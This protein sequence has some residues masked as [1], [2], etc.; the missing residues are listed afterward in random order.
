MMMMNR[1][2]VIGRKSWCYSHGECKNVG[3]VTPTI[4]QEREG[5]CVKMTAD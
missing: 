4:E 1:G 5:I 3:E 2:G